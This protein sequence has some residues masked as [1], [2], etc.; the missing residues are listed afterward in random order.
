MDRECGSI[1][2]ARSGW[3]GMEFS[4]AGVGRGDLNGRSV[5]LGVNSKIFFSFSLIEN[6]VLSVLNL[7]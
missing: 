1:Y 2:L 4:I 5:V 6:G 7:R 3:P